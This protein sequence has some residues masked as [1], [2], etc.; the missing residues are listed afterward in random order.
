MLRV[1]RAAAALFGDRSATVRRLHPDGGR[2]GPVL[3]SFAAYGGFDVGLFLLVFFLIYGGFHFYF[4]LK[5]R[6][7]FAPGAVIQMILIAFLILAMMAPIIVRVS[8]RYGF[9]TLARVMSWAGYVWMAVLL[10][11]FSVSLLIDLYRLLIHIS[12]LL[13]GTGAGLWIPSSRTAFSL[14]A[15]I[16]LAMVV[17]GSFEALNVR[18]ETLEIRS[19]KIPKSVERIRIVQISDVHVGVLVQ[20]KRLERI[21]RKVREAAPDLLVSTGDLVDGQIDSMTEAAAQLR[22]ILPRHG[23]FA[24]TGNHE[25]YA[26]IDEAL[27]FTAKAGFTALRGG[28]VTVADAIDLVGVDD[29]GM[30]GPGLEGRSSDRE[31][32]TRA[33]P[34]HFTILL[35]HQ[36]RVEQDGSGAF[37]L[38]LS[39]HTPRG[40][41]FPFSLITRLVFP[42]HSGNYRL[43]DGALLHVSRGTGTWGPPVRF[44][45][46][47]EIT[48]IDLIPE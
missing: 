22:A 21:L 26:G 23:K 10:L 36:P 46:P 47:P 32:L 12:T 38:Q 45:S 9:E 31:V 5:V 33:N 40:Q 7:A 15:A 2:V 24:V 3:L 34:G 8:E 35:K 14:P 13:S 18:T 17:Y 37:D 25:F 41:I 6:A 44:L 39:G 1:S 29:P 19:A 28:V 20:G 27:D 30:H 16:A 4:F 43:A 42:F 48:V 11:F